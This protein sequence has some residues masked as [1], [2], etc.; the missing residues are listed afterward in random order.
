MLE[1]HA[2]FHFEISVS[3][4]PH[5]RS[6]T[7]CIT[8]PLCWLCWCP[9][10]WQSPNVPRLRYRRRLAPDNLL[11][12]SFSPVPCFFRGPELR[13]RL[14]AATRKGRSGQGQGQKQGQGT[15]ISHRW[16]SVA[17]HRRVFSNS[18][19]TGMLNI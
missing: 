10:R 17:S 19:P 18:F 7:S 2:R 4:P 9:T 5:L 3:P 16:W 6:P 1:N 14:S 12:L 13:L 11:S 8:S 15:M